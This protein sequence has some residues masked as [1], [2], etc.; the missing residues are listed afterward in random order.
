MKTN[1]NFKTAIILTLFIFSFEIVF[2]SPNV[3]PQSIEKIEDKIGGG[4]TNTALEDSKND[5][6]F[7]YIAVGAI[8][9]GLIVWKVFLD[10][11]EPKTKDEIKTDSTKT[12]FNKS[13]YKNLSEQELQLEN[14]QNQIPFEIY[15]GVQNKPQSIPGSNLSL[16]LKFKL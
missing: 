1:I 10:K 16:G 12:S 15:L 2:L 4:G 14:I 13:F 5:N 3:F 9:V 11:K 8:F 7:L 6:T